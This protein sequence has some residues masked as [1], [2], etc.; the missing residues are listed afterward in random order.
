MT[1]HRDSRIAVAGA[2]SVGGYVGGCLALAGRTVTLL[3][4]PALLEDISRG[5]LRI[6]DLDGADRTLGPSAIPC[7]ADPASAFAGAGIILVTVKSGATEDMAKLIARHAPADAVVVSLQNGVGNLDRLRQYLPPPHRLVAGMVPFNVLQTR[8]CGGIARFHR[9]T[10]GTLLVS[11]GIE[12][13]RDLLD[14]RGLPVREHADMAAVLWGKL[15]LNLNNALNA[16]S[17]LPLAT[18]LADRRWRLLLAAQMEE[19]LGVLEAARIRLARIEGMP[20]RFIPLI[21]RLP[22]PLF[23][24]IA[25]RMLAIDPAARSSM[26]EDLERGR[27]SEIGYL[28]GAILD[29]AA[30]EGRSAPLS[31]RILRLIEVAEQAGA[32]S[33]K[34]GP[35]EISRDTA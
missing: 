32:G 30:R 16:L 28:Q 24:L 7:T 33:P 22:D 6:S 17:G 34:L 19:A 9:A 31:E 18:Q 29:L 25:R 13:L 5:G 12:G 35:G 11:T 15:L 2:G 20:P 4:R 10:S 26:W 27:P 8:D 21:L 14:V 1:P 23:R 3:S